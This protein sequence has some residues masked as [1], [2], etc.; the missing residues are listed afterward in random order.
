M[1][2]EDVD[3]FVR[4]HQA[5]RNDLTLRAP[6]LKH[7][8]NKAIAQFGLGSIGAPSALEFARA[9]IGDLRVCDFDSVDPG[10]MLRWPFGLSV[11]GLNKVD[12]IQ[13]FIQRN[14]P[15]TKISAYQRKVGTIRPAIPGVESEDQFIERVC[16]QASLIYDATAEYGVQHFLSDWAHSRHVKYV[17]VQGTFGGWGGKVINID[18]ERTKGCWICCQ[19]ASRDEI[20]DHPFAAPEATG[21][22]QAVGCGDITFTGAGFDLCQIALSGV[23]VALGALGDGAVGTY[24]A[25]DWDVLIINLRNKDGSAAPPQFKSYKLEK[26][27]NCPRCNPL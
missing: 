24:P 14:Y 7:L 25:A 16:D 1:P 17:G 2:L 13:R 8:T 22:I 11:L 27:P 10:T 15:Y 9:G 18:P 5:G 21:T 6:E 3:H 26:H 4:A 20:I 23:R 12:V 19:L